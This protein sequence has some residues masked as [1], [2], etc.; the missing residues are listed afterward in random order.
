M[1]NGAVVES[2][3]ATELGL[4]RLLGPVPRGTVHSS[5]IGLVPKAR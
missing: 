5:P 4:G 3:I 2:Y 1:S